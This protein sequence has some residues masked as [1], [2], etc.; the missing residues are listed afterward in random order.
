MADTPADKATPHGQRYEIGYGKPPRH[1][2]FE[3]GRSGNPRGRP[4]S[5]KNLATLLAAALDQR[6][7]VSENGR[8]KMITK[9][10]A[11]IAQLVNK[12]ASADLK[13]M[14]MLIGLLQQVERRA[15]AAPAEPKPLAEADQRVLQTLLGRLQDCTEDADAP[16]A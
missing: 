2:R 6:I 15:E 14:A 9:R 12:S 10:E 16:D 8:R 5:S 4:K 3:K 13:A 7:P 11:I 1:T